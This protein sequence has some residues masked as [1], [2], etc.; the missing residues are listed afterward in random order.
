MR[1]L[2]DC[3]TYEM[4]QIHPP[5]TEIP[6]R[7]SSSSFFRRFLHFYRKPLS[8]PSDFSM[9]GTTNEEVIRVLIHRLTYLNEIWAGGKFRCP[10][11]TMAIVK[12]EEALMW[13]EKR[14]AGR[15]IKSSTHER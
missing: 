7:P 6:A 5:G 12:L 10:E 2:D 14:E 13:L 1:C 8:G 3:H 15:A 4:E 11:N 9:I